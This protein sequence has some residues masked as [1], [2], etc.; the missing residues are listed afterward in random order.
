MNQIDVYEF[1]MRTVKSL[2]GKSRNGLH[3]GR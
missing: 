2:D 3:V 1:T